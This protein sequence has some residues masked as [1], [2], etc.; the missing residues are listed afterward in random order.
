MR[1]LQKTQ[2]Q[3]VF[4]TLSQLAANPA[5]YPFI[6][7]RSVTRAI[8]RVGT[9][10]SMA[11]V[12]TS[13]SRH[14]HQNMCNRL[15]LTLFRLSISWTWSFSTTSPRRHTQPSASIPRPGISG[16]MRSRVEPRARTLSCAPSCPS[17]LYTC[18]NTDQNESTTISLMQSLTTIMQ[19]ARPLR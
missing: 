16:R 6:P 5:M 7:D 10:S 1:H 11:L 15:L 19:V 8:R 9:A 14:L 18:R 17:Q 4:G 2:D 13:V 3:G 12:V